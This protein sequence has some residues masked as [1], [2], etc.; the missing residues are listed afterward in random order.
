[1]E[2][3]DTP[4]RNDME[5]EGALGACLSNRWILLV[6]EARVRFCLCA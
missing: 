6:K 4:V 1:M 2:L 5:V 3:I